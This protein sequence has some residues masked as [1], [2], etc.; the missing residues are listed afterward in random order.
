MRL[1]VILSVAGAATV[2]LGVILVILGLAMRSL[3]RHPAGSMTRLG[4]DVGAAGIAIGL[5]VLVVFPFPRG[6]GPGRR[7]A[8]SHVTNPTSVYSPGVLLDVPR[9]VRGPEDPRT[10]EHRAAGKPRGPG[11]P[12]HL[13][14][15]R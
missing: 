7:S 12:A 15:P 4:L 13:A 3:T 14:H 2:T 11:H 8:R 10:R 6:R 1:V 5:I 9:D